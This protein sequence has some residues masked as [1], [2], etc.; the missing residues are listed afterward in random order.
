MCYISSTVARKR[1]CLQSLAG[2]QGVRK[3]QDQVPVLLIRQNC[4]LLRPLNYEGLIM[5]IH[6]TKIHIMKIH[7][8][9]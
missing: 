9:L 8:T 1:Q 7:I 6:I 2:V 4:C 5:K 3:V